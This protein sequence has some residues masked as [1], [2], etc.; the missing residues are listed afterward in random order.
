MTSRRRASLLVLALPAVALA[1]CGSSS[2][3]TLSKSDLVA[4]ADKIC[5]NYNAKAKKL[6]QPNDI[7]NAA[8]AATYFQSAHDLAQQQADE[9]AALKPADDVKDQW[10]AYVQANKQGTDYLQQLADAAKA[11]DAT[12]GQQLLGGYQGLADSI[13]SKADALGAKACGSNSGG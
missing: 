4:K 8:Q 3:S 12:K 11:K 7:T 10:N 5:A 13:N 2:D 6:A 9:F 1:A